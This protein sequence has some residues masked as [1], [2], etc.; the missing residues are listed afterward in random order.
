[1]PNILREDFVIDSFLN[2]KQYIYFNRQIFVN[3][4]HSLFLLNKRYNKGTTKLF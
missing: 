2:G 3:C 4:L 1:M